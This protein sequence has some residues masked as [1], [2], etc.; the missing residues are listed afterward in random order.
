M[1]SFIEMG[2]L[3]WRAK[4]S[5]R[6]EWRKGGREQGSPERGKALRRL[7]SLLRAEKRYDD[8]RQRE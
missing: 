5:K 2:G 1:V 4:V 8:R 6:A 3:V 7:K